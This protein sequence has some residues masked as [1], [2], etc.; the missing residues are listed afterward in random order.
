[1]FVWIIDL[2]VIRPS[3]HPEVPTHP[4]TPKMLWTKE[5]N[6]TH[7]PSNVF[8]FGFTNESIKEFGGPSMFITFFIDSS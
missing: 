6:I 2:L 3:P 7:Y 4:F 5:R 8:T 1:M